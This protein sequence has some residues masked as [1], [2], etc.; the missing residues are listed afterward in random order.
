VIWGAFYPLMSVIFPRVAFIPHCRWTFAN[1]MHIF[2]FNYCL[3][4]R[5]SGLNT[6]RVILCSIS[7]SCWIMPSINSSAGHNSSEQTPET[8]CPHLKKLSEQKEAA[9]KDAISP[10]DPASSHPQG[11]YWLYPQQTKGYYFYG[12]LIFSASIVSFS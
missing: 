2:Y 12:I 5:N 10:A 3:F 7:C 1:I 9:Q 11:M 8:M 4:S 6:W